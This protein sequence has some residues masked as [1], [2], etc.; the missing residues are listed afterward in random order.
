M[1]APNRIKQAVAAT[2]FTSV[3]AVS[4][5]GTRMVPSVKTEEKLKADLER[6]KRLQQVTL[7]I[8]KKYGKNA[9]LK[10]MDL[11][12]GATAKQRNETI[13]GHKA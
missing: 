10:G 1:K 3:L 13:G 5:Y 7:T 8:K 4:A 11:D 9:V 2:F 12:E 6:E